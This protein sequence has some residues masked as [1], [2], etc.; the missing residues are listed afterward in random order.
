[1]KPPIILLYFCFLLSSTAYSQSCMDVEYKISSQVDVD[2]F[3]RVYGHCTSMP[4]M[5]ISIR[6][7]DSIDFSSLDFIEELRSLFFFSLDSK[8]KELDCFNRLK[9]INSHFLLTRFDSLERLKVLGS[10][11]HVPRI[12]VNNCEK[13]SIVDIGGSVSYLEDLNLSF[14]PVISELRGFPKLEQV[15]H[16][17]KQ[18]L[19]KRHK[20]PATMRKVNHFVIG[21]D[22]AGT[23][24]QGH[25]THVDSVRWLSISNS[26]SLNNL[27]GLHDLEAYGDTI[28][29][30]FRSNRNLNDCFSPF[31]C[32]VLDRDGRLFISF[33][34]QGCM[35][36]PEIKSQCDLCKEADT[37]SVV[38]RSQAEVDAY[39]DKYSVCRNIEGRIHII[40]DWDLRGLIK[41]HRLRG[42]RLSSMQIGDLSGLD[43]LKYVGSLTI[44]SSPMVEKITPLPKLK[45]VDRLSIYRLGRLEDLD[46]LSSLESIGRLDL[47]IYGGETLAGLD[48]LKIITEEVRVINNRNLT[49]LQGLEGL[50]EMPQRI[51][52][53][54][55]LSLS[56]IATIGEKELRSS[57]LTISVNPQLSICDHRGICTY[58][59]DPPQ[60]SYI[61]ITGNKEGC[62]ST[63]E[64]LVACDGIISTTDQEVD[65]LRI[66]P[67]PS[68]GRIYISG[69]RPTMWCVWC[70]CWARKCLS[71]KGQIKCWT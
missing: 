12:S 2:S 14:C 44:D 43:S 35:R 16:L 34:G 33:N 21:A 8:R 27:E 41:V 32:K 60:N 59:K 15:K 69:T 54:N 49:S 4:E 65:A 6:D 17:E 61:N 47:N 31:F 68:T 29:A 38:L 70:L 9:R 19:A 62:N 13:L 26:D 10:V 64:I 28:R 48:S 45:K 5:G 50:Q 53:H 39:V 71:M 57:E 24:L 11:E 67:N 37:L 55:N 56:D 42:L 51:I 58:L 52:L 20:W 23:D 36:V 1:M 40:G 22:N 3:V 66:Y 46:F 63:E 30:T 7:H 25:F 18:V